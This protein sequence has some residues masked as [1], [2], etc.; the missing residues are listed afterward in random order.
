MKKNINKH[1]QRC[2]NRSD[3]SNQP[4]PLSLSRERELDHMG[5]F[6]DSQVTKWPFWGPWKDHEPDVLDPVR[7]FSVVLKAPLLSNR[8]HFDTTEQWYFQ[9]HNSDNLL[10]WELVH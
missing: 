5:P 10:S 3:F 9:E 2:Q 4:P 7:G 8:P 6:L 1:L